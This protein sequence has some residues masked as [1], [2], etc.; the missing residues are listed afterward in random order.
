MPVLDPFASFVYTQPTGNP[1]AGFTSGGYPYPTGYASLPDVISRINAGSW[2]PTDP[3]AAPNAAQVQQWLME[4]TANIDVALATRGYFVPLQP[5][6]SFSAPVGTT[7]WNG[8]GIG[9]WLMLRNIAAAYASHYVETARHGENT[10]GQHDAQ[11]KSWLDIYGAMLG[12]IET[13]SANLEAFG[14][15]GAFEPDINPSQ[16]LGSGSLGVVL[17]DSS[18]QEGPLFT[19]GM[20]LGS[21]WEPSLGPGQNFG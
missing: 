9:A 18:R 7:T 11:A 14:V 2:D 21:G 20:N 3:T 19:R 13:A 1:V 10:V 6:G 16:G 5:A 4:A 12:E 8:V 15:G 17:S